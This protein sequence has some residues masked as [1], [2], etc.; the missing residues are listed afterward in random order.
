MPASTKDRKFYLRTPDLEFRL[1]GPIKI[2]NVITDMTLPQD[3]ITFLDPLPKIIPGSGYSKGKTESE[4]HASVNAG[5]SAKLYDVF[6]GQAEAKT[7]S[8]LKTIYAFDKVSAWYLEKNPTAADAEKFR[9]KDDE[10]KNALRNG[11]VYIVTGLKIA[12]G[13]RYSNQRASEHKAALSGGG[14]VTQEATV[15][16]RLEGE[17]GGE[18]TD[19]WTVLGD[20]ILAYRLHIM[21]TKGWSW[22]GEG[23]LTA[24][25]YDPGDAGFMNRED[26][27]DEFEVDTDE[28]LPKDIGFFAMEQE[29][30]GVHYLDFE[31]E[32]EEWSL[33]VLEG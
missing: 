17:L 14:H 12:K 33:T 21:K 29:F 32:E 8:S 20:P 28:V 18:N 26:E 15:E 7:S 5:L 23:N 4:H 22:K 30:E 16:G 25:T 3:P 27:V 10:F 31:D 11:P 19:T 2:G 24:K 6:G 1:N 9:E 13:L